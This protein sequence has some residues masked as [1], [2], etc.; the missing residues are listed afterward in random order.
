MDNKFKAG[1]YNRIVKALNANPNIDNI[2][3][4]ESDSYII[5]CR[6]CG[7]INFEF[8]LR[9]NTDLLIIKAAT[10]VIE[11]I[12]E[13]GI[14]ELGAE[15]VENTDIRS[16]TYDNKLSFQSVVPFLDEPEK[17]TYNNV[18]GQKMIFN[19]TLSFIQLM[20][21][22]KDRLGCNGSSSASMNIDFTSEAEDD[23]FGFNDYSDG[24]EEE[25]IL[26]PDISD[27]DD[28]FSN[29]QTIS[30]EKPGDDIDLIFGGSLSRPETNDKLGLQQDICDTYDEVSLKMK[31]LEAKKAEREKR[32]SQRK[33]G[34]HKKNNAKNSSGSKQ[35]KQA[36]ENEFIEIKTAIPKK[37]EADLF[38]RK[39]D[40][41]FSNIFGN[42]FDDRPNVPEEHVPSIEINPNIKT[43]VPKPSRLK[44][45]RPSFGQDKNNKGV[46]LMDRNAKNIHTEAISPVKY[47]RA[48]EV[49][50]QMKHLYAE[51]DDVFAKRKEQ[52][53]YREE[54]LNNYAARLD[55]RE[56]ELAVRAERLE[57]NHAE[58]QQEHDKKILE[59]ETQNQEI[60]FQWSKLETEQALLE[61]KKKDIE[62]ERRLLDKEKELANIVQD[63][64]EKAAVHKYEI[65]S[66]N[67]EINKLK[68][69]KT[70]L[71]EEYKEQVKCLQDELNSLYRN[72]ASSDKINALQEKISSL[73]DDIAYLNED[74]S[75]LNDEVIQK[76]EIIS[77]LQK[78][79]SEW[80]EK[81]N[82]WVSKEVS[83]KKQIDESS[84]NSM[85]NEQLQDELDA[86]YVKIKELTAEN[87]KNAGIPAENTEEIS[88]LNEEISQLKLKLE[89][90][91]SEY[92][93]A[94]KDA[95]Q[96]ASGKP[97]GVDTNK[98]AVS[99]KDSLSEIGIQVEPV[100]TNGELVLSGYSD[101][102]K[103]IINVDAGVLYISK[104]VKRGVKFRADFE[105]WN[106]EDIRTSYLFGE[107]EVICKCVYD[108]VSKAAM[109]ILGRFERMH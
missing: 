8:T 58:M 108:D 3:K 22:Y 53:D 105:K 62:E 90:A 45:S 56:K 64:D 12:D 86:A 11:G 91:N 2:T 77:M 15:I 83:Y 109:D 49:V 59:F 98:L 29:I 19:Q 44:P 76:D 46:R 96:A 57:Q 89:K 65:E 21:K 35:A 38:E 10:P 17:Q 72:A 94:K 82:S 50:E 7:G 66:K 88:K 80:K 75:D 69:E 18:D 93:K 16:V 102:S 30:A 106:Q 52:M 63:E 99:I 54:T 92:E 14:T 78:K 9:K 67:K 1:V 41:E 107:K 73:E 20:C 60:Q 24:E 81:E 32:K 51:V 85:A 39:N 5:T 103:V 87:A 84:G 101:V 79:Q 68:A 4:E 43:P 95:E 71:D 104:P 48:P 34:K 33:N 31:E 25:L 28:I 13:S 36:D 70:A 23:P 42:I 74:V 55:Q 100:A 6:I 40:D 47:E 37:P 26:K 27:E 97:S 61:Q